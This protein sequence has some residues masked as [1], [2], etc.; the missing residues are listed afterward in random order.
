[1]GDRDEGGGVAPESNATTGRDHQ[2]FV[3]KNIR[4]VKSPVKRKEEKQ[5]EKETERE[6]EKEKNKKREEEEEKKKK[7]REEKKKEK[8]K[9]KKKKKE[10]GK[11]GNPEEK[12]FEKR[13][14]GIRDTGGN[15]E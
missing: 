2:N 3:K 5:R 15:K 1:M 6:I 11:K 4:D 9:K 10:K 12:L 8:K 14:P 13:E 7:K